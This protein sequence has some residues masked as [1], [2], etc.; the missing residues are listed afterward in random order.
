MSQPDTVSTSTASFRIEIVALRGSLA[1][2]E[3]SNPWP[4]RC[5]EAR[6]TVQCSLQ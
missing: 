1:R 3:P 5:R 6:A 2:V 4:N